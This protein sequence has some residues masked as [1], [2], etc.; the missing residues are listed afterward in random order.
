M[1]SDLKYH[2][3]E[4]VIGYTLEA[5]A[6]S[7]WNDLPILINQ[8][9]DH[10]PCEFISKDFDCELFG[11]KNQT[12]LIKTNEGSFEFNIQKEELRW[13]IFY[14]LNLSGKSPFSH[15][16]SSISLD[17][18]NKLGVS[19]GGGD[20]STITYNKLYIFNVENI[21]NLPTPSIFNPKFQVLDWIETT[22]ISSHNFDS[23][24]HTGFPDEIWFFSSVKQG[25]NLTK[26][27]LSI[28]YMT[29]EELTDP[30]NSD[31]NIRLVIKN[32]L[33]VSGIAP[34]RSENNRRAINLSPLERDIRIKDEYVYENLP[35]IKF[36]D[37]SLEDV[38]SKE[39]KT[40]GTTSLVWNILS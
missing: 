39:R 10:L 9:T 5:I 11:V 3:E 30:E 6:F 16:I 12:N 33:N 4:L 18:N 21:L 19:L 20:R 29:P 24:K 22:H 7:F 35:N 1:R 36:L 2:I 34:R 17:E 13:N 32:L 27:I 25:R 40:S 14:Y 37:L 8:R 28:T 26:D 38:I 15:T 23:I 31:T